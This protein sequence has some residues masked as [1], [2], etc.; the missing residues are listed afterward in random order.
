MPAMAIELI[1]TYSLI[2]DDLPCMDDDDMRRGKPTLHRMYNE[3]QAVL[4]GDLLLTYSFELLASSDLTPQKRLSLISILAQRSGGSGMIL[5]QSMDLAMK[6]KTLSWND[7][8][9]LHLRKTGDLISAA[10]EM[11]AIIADTSLEVQATMRQ[12]GQYS[13]LAF[14]LVDD[15]LDKE[16]L[17][18]QTLSSHALL[19][20]ALDLCQSLGLQDSCLTQ[21]LPKL[22]SRAF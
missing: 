19:D 9:E 8:Q 15:L 10:C 14:Q 22:I 12:I 6:G 5:G 3:G 16:H 1:H 4:V 18:S 13:G 11:G 21:F 17:S 2:H 20:Q 7:L